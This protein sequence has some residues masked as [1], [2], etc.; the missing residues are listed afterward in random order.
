MSHHFRISCFTSSHPALPIKCRVTSPEPRTPKPSIR[1]SELSTLVSVGCILC[2]G[3][4]VIENMTYEPSLSCF[5]FHILTSRPHYQVPSP[6][7]RTPA[8][9]TRDPGLG[10]QHFIIEAG[11]ASQLSGVPSA[12]SRTPAIYQFGVWGSVKS[13]SHLKCRVLCFGTRYPGAQGTLF[14]T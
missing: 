8:S 4:R 3:I 10:A 12:Q 11:Q 6:E 5:V 14:D 9:G 2:R 1:D 13:V 7:P